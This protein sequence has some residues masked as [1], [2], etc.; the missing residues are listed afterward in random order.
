MAPVIMRKFKSLL[1]DNHLSWW[2]VILLFAAEIFLNVFV[3]LKIP[4]TEIDWKAYM[5]EVEGVVNGSYNYTTLKGD[6]G[7]LVYPA[8]FVYIFMA[9]YF[10]TGYGRNIRVAQFIFAIFYLLTFVLVFNIYR[11][12][13]K[14][15]AY[16]LI[17]MCGISYRIHSIYLLRLFND[18]VAM[19]FLYAAINWFLIG[20]WSVGCV[21][22]SVAV[23]IK[24]NILLFSPALLML[25]LSSQ[26]LVKTGLHLA[27][28]AMIQ[29]V[30]GLP[31]LMTNP[32]GYVKMSFDLGRQFMYKWTVNWR[33]IPLDTFENRNFHI[34]LLMLHIVFLI[35]FA[36]YKWSP[37]FGNMKTVIT[38]YRK[39]VLN[40]L[41]SNDI[42]LPLFTANFIGVTFSRSLH[43]QFY[44]WYF[45][46]LPYLLWSTRY[47]VVL[48]LLMLVA[49]EL[50]W[51]TYPST[52][53]SSGLLHLCHLV[54]LIGL[55]SAPF[56]A[57]L[58]K[59]I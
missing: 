32:W 30:L 59:R 54:L 13:K 27:L 9:L 4:Y 28:C 44:V 22:Y 40:I 24:M 25:L 2:I 31:F 14:V 47:P 1:R 45:H 17:L 15:P 55:I 56:K 53:W 16:V 37:M 8:G 26:G 12:T 57:T 3:I 34:L 7:P 50:C 49:I 29:V 19:I 21:F 39:P 41:R 42:I 23:S 10:V 58:K 46:T 33:C 52:V 51:N 20:R 11:I 43:Y 36:Y 5:Q 6:T 18:P 35:L 48:R 38:K